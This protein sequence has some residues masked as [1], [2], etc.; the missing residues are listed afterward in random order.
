MSVAYIKGWRRSVTALIVAEGLRELSIDFAE[1]T[2]NYKA[3]EKYVGHLCSICRHHF[4]HSAD[5]IFR[6]WCFSK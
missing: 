1:L 2:G 4:E 6:T 3:S 5:C